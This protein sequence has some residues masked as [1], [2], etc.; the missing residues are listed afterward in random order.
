MMTRLLLLAAAVLASPVSVAFESRLAAGLAVA[1]ERVPE[2]VA[3]DGVPM[4]L[5]RVTGAGVPELVRRIE[6]LWRSQ[7]S[8]VRALNQGVWIL[9]S[10]MQG[11]KSEV[12]QW[13]NGLDISELL[14]SSLDAAG[15]VQPIPEAGLT[16][17]AGCAWGRSVAGSSGQHHYLQRTARCTHAL[18]ELSMQLQRTLPPQGWRLRT[19]NDHALVLERQGVEGIL[20][21]AAQPGD[22]ATWLTWLRVEHPQ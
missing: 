22:P 21:L 11:T 19:A 3:V 12:M 15:Q 2:P 9:R 10:R 13:R 20:S 16:L 1:I 18:R 5:Q 8:E 14:W 6:E 17:P 4:T 7:G